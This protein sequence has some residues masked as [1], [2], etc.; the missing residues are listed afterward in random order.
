MTNQRSVKRRR[1]ARVEKLPEPARSLGK[2]VVSETKSTE[3]SDQ[4][5]ETQS[6]EQ[7]EEW[8]ASRAP[9]AHIERQRK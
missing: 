6:A 5:P 4:D 9:G 1:N 8:V 3:G 7:M 2:K